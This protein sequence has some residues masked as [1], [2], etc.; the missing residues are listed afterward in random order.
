MAIISMVE[1]RINQMRVSV[2][3]AGECGVTLVKNVLLQAPLIDLTH[4]YL[5]TGS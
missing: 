1:A 3:G 4:S 2:S 5:K